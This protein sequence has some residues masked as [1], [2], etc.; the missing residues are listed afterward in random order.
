MVGIANLSLA[1]GRTRRRLGLTK[2]E[3]LAREHVDSDHPDLKRT[4]DE[5]RARISADAYDA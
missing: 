1:D 5:L 2:G 3:T 4:D